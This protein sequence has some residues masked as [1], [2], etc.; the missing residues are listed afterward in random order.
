MTEDKKDKSEIKNEIEQEYENFGISIPFIATIVLVHA[1][2][3]VSV[4]DYQDYLKVK[5]DLLQ[6][7]IDKTEIQLA[8]EKEDS[9]DEI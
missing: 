5:G 8:D 4:K 1:R 2:Y 3:K 9:Q 7:A 6:K